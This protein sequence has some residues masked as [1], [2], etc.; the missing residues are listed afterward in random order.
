MK[1][2]LAAA[3]LAV[4][5]LCPVA[6]QAVLLTYELVL[7]GPAESP[8]QASPGT[9]FGDLFVDT[10]AQTMEV[11]VAFQ[12]LIGTTTA[13]HV[14]CCTAAPFTGTAIVATT[15]PT[16][17][18]FPL[19][20]TSG[21]YDRTF[22]LTQAATYNPAFVN[23][24]GGTVA[25]AEATLLQ[26]L[27]LGEAYLNIHTT[28]VPGGEIRSFARLVAVPEP[29]TLALLGAAMAGLAATRRRRT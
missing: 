27:S 15:V 16:F 3:A 23:A 24:N 8:P 7:S 11:R 4:A 10:L 29:A 1:P 18:G 2:T 12:G 22:D 6:A 17:P 5:L 26:G 19:G 13:S 14:H 21:T 20:V 9:G 25:S 28:F